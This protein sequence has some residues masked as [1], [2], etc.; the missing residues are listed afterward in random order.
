MLVQVVLDHITD[1]EAYD[2]ADVGHKLALE[3]VVEGQLDAPKDQ[4]RAKAEGGV[5]R[6][7]PRVAGER[8]ISVF[9]H[10]VFVSDVLEDKPGPGAK[11]DAA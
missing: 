1:A 9:E 8:W 7:F 5:D 3:D 2:A 4:R 11:G 10:P 6:E